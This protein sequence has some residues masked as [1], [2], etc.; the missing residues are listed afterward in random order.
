MMLVK[1]HTKDGFKVLM[2]TRHRDVNVHLDFITIIM[3]SSRSAQRARAREETELIPATCAKC[4][5][6]KIKNMQC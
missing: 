6:Q 3:V 4:A 2:A 1:V 5:K